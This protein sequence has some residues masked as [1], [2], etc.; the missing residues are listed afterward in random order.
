MQIAADALSAM[1]D[2]GLPGALLAWITLHRNGAAY[3]HLFAEP[4]A[5]FMARLELSPI[6]E[7]HP[8]LL[9]QASYIMTEMYP[10]TDK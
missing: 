8:N 6:R 1:K 7:T 5:E 9:E 4:P 3:A 10:S 2:H